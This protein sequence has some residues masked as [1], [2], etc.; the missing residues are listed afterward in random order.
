MSVDQL[1]DLGYEVEISFEGEDFTTYHVAGFGLATY[2][3]ADDEETLA[4]LADPEA[5]AERVKALEE[6][7]AET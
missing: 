1:R 7:E 3:R 6:A 2:V 4:A 5:H